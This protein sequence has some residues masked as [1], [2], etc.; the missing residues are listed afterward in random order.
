MHFSWFLLE[1]IIFLFVFSLSL[2]HCKSKKKFR[3]DKKATLITRD[4][5][6]GPKPELVDVHRPV[7]QAPPTL[8]P[9]ETTNENDDTMANVVTLKPDISK[10]PPAH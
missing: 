7:S 5:P 4:T 3:G 8:M 6:T 2:I 10:A 1:H 9:L